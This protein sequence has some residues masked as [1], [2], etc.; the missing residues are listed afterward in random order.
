MPNAQLCELAVILDRSGSMASIKRDMEGGFATFIAEQS[1]D[2]SPCVV[3][4]YQFDS[5]FETSYEERPL[6]AASLELVPRGSTALLDAMGKAITLIGERLKAKP[7]SE[8]P[9]KVVVLVIT[10]GQ[11]NASRE[12]RREAV[13]A[14][15]EH[16]RE[17]YN[18]QFAF[19]GANL[20]SFSEAM[21]IGMRKAAAA[22]FQASAQGVSSGY[23]LLSSSL[24]DYRRGYGA[25]G[26]A[27][28]SFNLTPE[29][30]EK[31]K[32]P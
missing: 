6:S 20:D 19:L 13:K 3:S 26:Q 8:R 14:A 27:C 22:N 9:G 11:E 31:E 21:S 25:G 30:E 16:Q 24:R 7:E 10:D 4:L 5:T 28:Q 29:D 1:K 32:A 12:W 18:W 17:K 2:P 15:V 23:G